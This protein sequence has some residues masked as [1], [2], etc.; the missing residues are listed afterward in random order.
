M[1]KTVITK[2]SYLTF[3]SFMFSAAMVAWGATLLGVT[4]FFAHL[5]PDL[6]NLSG[7]PLRLYLFGGI[8]YGCVLICFYWLYTEKIVP[9]FPPTNLFLLTLDFI[10]LTFMIGAA[11]AWR[12]YQNFNNLALCTLILLMLRF[13]WA[14]YLEFHSGKSIEKIS[15]N[16]LM[17]HIVMVYAL[18]FAL[19]VIL[20]AGAIIFGDISLFEN[21]SSDKISLLKIWTGIDKKAIGFQYKLYF[22]VC[23]TMLIGIIV[24]GYHSFKQNLQIENIFTSD[25]TLNYYAV[26]PNISPTLVPDYSS[27]KDSI[28][29]VSKGVF[30]GEK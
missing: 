14:S 21:S 23:I 10:A 15:G 9:T 18:C 2:N 1:A 16:K 19:F 29:L 28:G 8:L 4:G 20:I 27:I 3:I 7:F 13:G 24:V 22:A 5:T 25:K 11:A 6:E 17:T 30:E 26:E 12:N